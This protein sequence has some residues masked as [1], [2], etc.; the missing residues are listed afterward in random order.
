MNPILENKVRGRVLFHEDDLLYKTINRKLYVSHNAGADWKQVYKLPITSIFDFV[1]DQAH[2]AIRLLRKGYHHLDL[3]V[4]EQIGILYDK[5][6]AIITDKNVVYGKDIKGSRP[7]SFKAINGEFIFGEYRSNPERS[8]IGV[9]AFNNSKALY[10]KLEISGIR[11]V[12]GI[13]KDPYTNRVWITSGDFFEEA[14]IYNADLELKN[15]HKVISG[16]QQT[17]AI[18]LLFTQDFIY[19][20]TD[21]PDEQNFI[22]R[23]SRDDYHLEKLASVGSSVFH[24]YQLSNWLFFSTAVEPSKV[25]KTKFVELW[26]S[27][28]GIDWKC[29]LKLK[30]DNWSMKY[31]QYGQLF[32]PNGEGDSKGLWISPFATKYSNYSFY[33]PLVV[34]KKLWG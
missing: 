14:C 8:S 33:V 7:L 9:Y 10:K 11:H 28:D 26:A 16:S 6:A 5:K 3:L 24:G 2:L 19:Y 12:H 30:K 27:P 21:T 17:R 23:F 22:Y 25:N 1:A 13:Y 18:K 29:I 32:F 31:F 34:I 20:G 15:I 4:G